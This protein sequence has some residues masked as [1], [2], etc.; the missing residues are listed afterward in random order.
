[1]ASPLYRDELGS[2]I[3]ARPDVVAA[4]AFYLLY[5]VGVVH[6]VVLPAVRDGGWS[7]AV[8]RGA[9]LGAVAYGTFGLTNR[10]VLTGWPWTLTLIDLAWGAVLTAVTAGVACRAATAIVRR[11]A[12]D[13]PN[14]SP[15]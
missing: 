12:V 13:D 10:A 6:L 11:R 5:L 8:A 14:E 9:G 4:A 2:A 7:A 15:R 3:A 1:M